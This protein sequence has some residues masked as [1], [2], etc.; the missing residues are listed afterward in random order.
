VN[1][2][3]VRTAYHTICWGG[4]TGDPVGV[5]SIKDLFYRSYGDITRA[6]D[7]IAELGFDGFE[8]FDGNVMDYEGDLDAFRSIIQRAGIDLLAVY[9]GGNFVFNEIRQEELSRVRRAAAVAGQ[10]EARYLV[11]GGGAQRAGGPA[12]GDYSRLAATLDEIVEI[13]DREGLQAVYHPHLTTLAESPE[14]VAKVLELSRIDLCADTAHL[15]AGGG[16]PEQ[17]IR[18]HADR[19]RYVHLKDLQREP[20]AFMPL[21][22]GELDLT[23]V[24]NALDDVG[25]EGWVTVELDSYDG[26]PGEAAR[27]SKEF[28]RQA[29]IQR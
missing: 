4:V 29:G 25:Y 5:T 14:Q 13:A 20:F 27:I 12:D 7:E 2:V 8:A 21:G 16:D 9:S 24:L 11:V 15:A 10:L 19:L 28:L 1:T 26:P 6:V 23:G 18:D 3:N 22:H 17:M